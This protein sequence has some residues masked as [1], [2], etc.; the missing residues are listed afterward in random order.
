MTSQEVNVLDVLILCGGKGTRL[1]SAVSDRPK[2]MAVLRGRPFL[3]WQLLSLRKGGFKNIVL[4]TGYMGMNIRDHFGDGDKL[5]LCIR[6]SE[7]HEARGTGGAIRSACALVQSDPVLVLNGDSWCDL[8]LARLISFHNTHEAMGTLALTT[9]AHS[10]R[11]GQVLL[12]R[13]E[14]VIGFSEKGKSETA[15]WINAGMY[16]L[17]HSFMESIPKQSYSSLEHDVFPNWVKKGLYGCSGERRFFDIGTPA[18]YAQAEQ[19]FEEVF[20]LPQLKRN[21]MRQTA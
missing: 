15:G 2:S 10:Q 18:S 12:G 20:H 7:E 21:S 6:Y 14:E 4:C 9:V 17:A 5:G 19:D 3:E 11:Y 13:S 1:R 16:V 8:D